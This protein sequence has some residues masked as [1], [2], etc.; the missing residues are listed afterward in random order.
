M[1]LLDLIWQWRR[2]LVIDHPV[3]GSLKLPGPERLAPQIANAEIRYV[4]R[5]EVAR[6]CAKLVYEQPAL[7]L[8]SIDLVRV[9]SETIWLEWYDHAASLP[10]SAR[11]AAHRRAGIYVETDAS[12]RR[13]VIRS[14]WEEVPD[15]PDRCPAAIEF[16]LDAVMTSRR[17]DPSGHP[18]GNGRE[19]LFRPLYD[20][21][22]L[23]VDE[24]WSRYYRAASTSIG[25]T[26]QQVEETVRPDALFF[27]AFCLLFTMRGEVEFHPSE[28]ERLNRARKKRG[29]PTLLEYR[30][31]SAKVFAEPGYSQLGKNSHSTRGPS[32]LHYVRGHFVR[33][34]SS[35]FWRSAHLRGDARQGVAARKIVSL[36][37]G[38]APSELGL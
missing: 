3:L 10:G 2:P 28:L 11:S 15:C 25:D 30:E 9:P 20:C 33:R 19:D 36:G 1:R 16:D 17:G 13:G 5:D 18:V 6:A 34:K 31:V 21:M 32:R 22:R 7:L 37:L 8:D 23:T 12:G 24:E 29:Q 38:R 35:I 4:L 27:L 26:L 14:A